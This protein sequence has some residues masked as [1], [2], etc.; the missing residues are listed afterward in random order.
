MSYKISTAN[1]TTSTTE[2]H[3]INLP[4]FVRS[5][6][7]VSSKLENSIC[8]WMFLTV[9][10]SKS[11]G[12]RNKKAFIE[13]KSSAHKQY[14]FSQSERFEKKTKTLDVYA[15]ERGKCLSVLSNIYNK[16]LEIGLR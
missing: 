1:I 2:S 15:V 14:I 4:K 3:E 13:I 6:T 11:W 8:T 9:S 12:K 16:I 10:S 7:K 5:T